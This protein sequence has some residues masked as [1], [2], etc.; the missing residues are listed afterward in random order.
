MK[1]FPI[2]LFSLGILILFA[3]SDGGSKRGHQRW[4]IEE[5]NQ[6]SEE[7]GWLRGSNFIPSNAINQLEMWQAETFDTVTIDRELGWAGNIGMNCMRVFLHHVVW[8]VDKES[9]KDR[10]EQYLSIADK[11]GIKTMFV[12]FDDCWNPVY[13]AGKQPEPVPQKHNSGWIQDPG[14]LLYQDSTALLP[15]LEEYVKDVLTHFKDD[16]RIAI[17]DLYNEPKEGKNREK[18]LPLLRHVFKWAREVGPSQPLTSAVWKL[19][20][21]E[22][23]H[24]QIEN[25]DVISY[26]TYDPPD[27]HQEL[28][29]TLKTFGRPM[30]CSEYMMRIN[31]SFFQNIMPMLKK[32]SIGAISWGLVTGKTNTRYPW[33]KFKND[34]LAYK[35]WFHDIFYDYGTPYDP[36]EIDTIM[37]LTEAPEPSAEE[38]LEWWHDA[39]FGMFIHWGVYS[40]YGGVYKGHHQAYGDAAWIENRCKI[41]V[42]EYREHAKDFNP[43][44]YDPDAW[45]KTAKEA[46]MKYLIITAKHHDGFALFDSK[47]SDWD[48]VDATKYGKD[49]LKPL[50]E[51]CKKYDIRLGFYY[52]Q[53]NDWTNPG[54]TVARRPM[55]QGWPNPDS[56]RIDRYTKE[57]NGSW[58]PVQETRAFDEYVD[59]VAIPQVKELLTNYGDVSVLWW[60]YATQMKSYQGAVKLKKL[61]NIQPN[62]ISNDRLHPDFP[63]DTKTPEQGIPK[64]DQINEEENWENC[65]TMNNSWGYKSF[66]DKWKSSEELIRNLVKNVARGGNY[67]L[68]VGPKADGTIPEES[69]ERL[70][71]I[72]KWMSANGEAVYETQMSPFGAIPWGECTCKE[73]GKNTTLYFFVFDW[74][75]NEKLFIPRLTNKVISAKLLATGDKIKTSENDKGTELTVPKVMPDTYATVINVEVKGEVKRNI[76]TENKERMRSGAID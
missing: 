22:V 48:V 4:S 1:S 16:K 24:F 18:S 38:R 62:I 49:L 6:W 37:A 36:V 41:P 2:L 34:S 69:V 59:Q 28:I 52:S 70:K 64:W 73:K 25:S 39:K 33:S 32:Q 15:V 74:P 12:F 58:D 31:N 21:K 42:A 19:R 45:V 53:A 47:A 68:N 43:V 11:H 57:H 35:I 13:Q 55:W 9:F 20:F 40:M 26:H 29:D 56:A 3:C 30:I 65:M 23:T 51:S 54:G 44:N 76:S 75:E 5:A 71:E 14:E 50:V 17:W 61:L 27:E 66:D 46:G 60:D 63:G 67:L 8:E 72:G 10:M 7:N